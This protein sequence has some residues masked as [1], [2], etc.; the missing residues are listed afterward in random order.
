MPTIAV[1]GNI[2]C[3]TVIR[4]DGALVSGEEYRATRVVRRL[5]GAAANRAVA[6]ACAGLNVRLA[7]TVGEDD[8][9]AHLISELSRQAIDQRNVRRRPGRSSE[10]FILVDDSGERTI[11]GLHRGPDPTPFPT[12]PFEGAEAIMVATSRTPPIEALRSAH[13]AGVPIV[14]SLR[15]PGPA[16]VRL[17]SKRSL[18]KWEIADPRA[19]QWCDDGPAEWLVVTDGVRGA[20]AY[21]ADR[22]VSVPAEPATVADATGAGDVFAAGV[23]AGLAHGFAIEDCLAV[24]AR[25]GARAVECDSSSVFGRLSV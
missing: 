5:G 18:V 2:N 11:V 14:A 16:A 1:I 12:E 19:A 17:V 4:L 6:L 13:A 24:G 22:T 8:I 20:T 3:D 7:G 21:G 9:G 25:W 23:A 15:T 10:C